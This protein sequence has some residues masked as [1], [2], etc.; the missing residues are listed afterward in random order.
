M[1]IYIMKD[2]AIPDFSSK[3]VLNSSSAQELKPV[4]EK[5]HLDRVCM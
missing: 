1:Q 3:L 4:M 5:E 2:G